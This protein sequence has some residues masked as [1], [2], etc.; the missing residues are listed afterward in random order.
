MRGLHLR[1][2]GGNANRIKR[3]Q[4]RIESTRV[5]ALQIARNDAERGK[6]ARRW[7]Y[8]NLRDLQFGCERGRVHR[9]GAAEC[10]K[11]EFARV[12]TALD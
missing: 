10:D 1:K 12:V 4:I 7:W 3:G 8:D 11:R 2:D 5:V 9:A 6:R